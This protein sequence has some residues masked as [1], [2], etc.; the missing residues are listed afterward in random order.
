MTHI[1]TWAQK[2]ETGG[3]SENERNYKTERDEYTG[4]QTEREWREL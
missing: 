3:K 1:R 2:G 4:E